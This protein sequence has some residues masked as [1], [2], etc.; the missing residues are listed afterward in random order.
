MM[1]SKPA[2]TLTTEL[3]AH[4]R[5]IDGPHRKG[6]RFAVALL[7]I[8]A[9]QVILYGP[10]LFGTKIA[11]PVD[12]NYQLSPKSTAV[13]RNLNHVL[14]D[15]IMQYE[16]SRQFVGA[17]LRAGRV[18]L[19]IPG[20]FCGAPLFTNTWSPFQWIYYAWPDPALLAWTVLLKS[21]VSGGGAF[22][23]FRRVTRVG[24]WPAVFGGSLFPLTMFF[25]LWQYYV[26]SSACTW[27]PWLLLSTDSA[28]RRPRGAGPIGVAIVTAAV[29]TETL[30]APWPHMLLA[31]GLYMLWCLVDEYGW[32]RIIVSP[33]A[34]RA[35][36]AMVCAWGLGGGLI[37]LQNLPSGDYLRSS[38]RVAARAEGLV[39][40][41]PSGWSA[42][43]EWLFPH[44]FGDMTVSTAYLRKKGNQL[45]AAASASSGLLAALVLAPLAFCDPRQRSRNLFWVGLGLFGMAYHVDI[46]IVS[47]IFRIFP[48]KVLRNNRFTF[49]TGWGTVALA[50]GGL[51]VLLTNRKC[52]RHF[53]WGIVL[54]LLVVTWDTNA[55]RM[56][57]PAGLRNIGSVGPAE[58]FRRLYRW[59]LLICL[60][61]LGAW[62]ALFRG[63][64]SGVTLAM[65]IG[66]MA[67][68][69]QIVNAWNVNPQCDRAF[70]YPPTAITEAV[71]NATPGR[72]A[73]GFYL[74]PNIGMMYGMSE[75]RGYD[76][77][78]PR[79][80][81]QLYQVADPDWIMADAHIVTLSFRPPPSPI[82]DMLNLRYVFYPGSPPEDATVFAKDR[83]GWLE[84]RTTALPRVYV[85]RR[86]V[87]AACLAQLGS[88]SFDPREVV[89]VPAE[90]SI[91]PASD[92]DGTAEIVAEDSMKVVVKARM[93]TPGVLVLADS[94]DA[95]WQ[96]TIDRRNVPV[97]RVNYLIR[98]VELP[99]GES[100]IEFRYEPATFTWGLRISAG[101][102]IVLVIWGSLLRRS[103]RKPDHDM[104][105]SGLASSH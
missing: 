47:D 69:E 98:G 84:E 44:H 77:A 15:P 79:R 91:P 97:S 83:N 104:P 8:L 72:V 88:D 70:Y 30:G 40:Q 32:R 42:W 64:W 78:N 68:G 27:L 7:A 16:P 52:W 4:P 34:L 19:W 63:R 2:K 58:W 29:F 100:T 18:P 99:A 6:V 26:I 10:S 89:Y 3:P 74:R 93:K 51:E 81:V 11:I 9:P 92:V 50:V 56:A 54:L 94:W 75:V 31:S 53:F 102:T 80:V 33:G 21:L 101:C 71:R 39:E 66:G 5:W 57:V 76:A 65:A 24:Y 20:I 28:V 1:T 14:G 55:A 13:P 49:F 22:L 87:T 23:F 60:T 82:M 45:E 12:L 86:I 43:E 35:M 48:F 96:A 85:P 105:T 95:G 90:A 38:H 36:A 73:M 59:E 37:A 41:P 46:P 67:V 25:T 62:W 17:E 103:K 61:A